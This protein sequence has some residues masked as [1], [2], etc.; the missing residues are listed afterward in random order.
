MTDERHEYALAANACTV[1]Q[2][3]EVIPYFMGFGIL[4]DSQEETAAECENLYRVASLIAYGNGFATINDI[5]HFTTVSDTSLAGVSD[6][7]GIQVV[8]PQSSRVGGSPKLEIPEQFTEGYDSLVGRREVIK[9]GKFQVFS[10]FAYGNNSKDEVHE[11]V[12]LLGSLIANYFARLSYI[13]FF[14]GLP[15]FEEPEGIR[16]AWLTLAQLPNK[17]SP[18]ICPACGKIVDRRRSKKGG[19]PSIACSKA[20]IDMYH[21]EQ[22]RLLKTPD[23]EMQLNNKRAEKA[24]QLRW[25]DDNNARPYTFSGIADLE[26]ELKNTGEVHLLENEYSPAI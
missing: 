22:K 24:R 13:G 3:K 25:Q 8:L 18:S 23:P 15:I 14:D 12:R 17:Q 10:L 7:I 16:G 11:L 9:G 26:E 2:Y 4:G 21:N 19:K 5:D 1:N 20:H 6:H